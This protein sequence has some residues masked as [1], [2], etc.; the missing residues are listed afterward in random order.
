M[1]SRTVFYISDGTGITAETLAHSL[2]T[3]FDTDHF[4]EVRIPFTDT[5]EKAARARQRVD[6]AEVNDDRRPLVFNTVIDPEISAELNRSKGLIVDLFGQFLPLLEKELKEARAR[7]IGRAHGI[8][9]SERY[10]QRISAMNFA[11]SHDDGIASSYEEAEVILLGVS[12]SGKTPTCL[13]LALHYGVRAANYPLTEDDLDALRL[14]NFLR[15]HK[16]KLFGLTIGADRLSQIRQQRRPDSRYASLRQC[17]REIADAEQM[18]QS[19]SVPWI[20]T[21]NSSIE[22]IA[23]KVLVTLGLEKHFF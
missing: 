20:Q 8:A 16:E 12:R 22:E 1:L 15:K 17:Q 4:R 23:S 5:P 19:E 21:T 13:Y 14:P 2:L 9:N 3:Q 7:T 11:L 6:Q 18:F 10:E